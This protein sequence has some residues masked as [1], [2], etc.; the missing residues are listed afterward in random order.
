ML[1]FKYLW[2]E[3]TI[4][5]VAKQF[6]EICQIV[7]PSGVCGRGIPLYAWF[8]N[9]E[10]FLA[11]LAM[12]GMAVKP[13]SLSVLMSELKLRHPARRFEKSCER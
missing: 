2:A 5:P 9:Q 11:A 13:S 1:R 12:T 10:R 4:S 7:N 6:A 8:F 3:R